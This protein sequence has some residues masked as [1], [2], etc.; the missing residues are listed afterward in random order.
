MKK[1][2][3]SEKWN[4]NVKR[5]FNEKWNFNDIWNFNEKISKEFLKMFKIAKISRFFNSRK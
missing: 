1:W 5:N 3:L 4:L 2:K